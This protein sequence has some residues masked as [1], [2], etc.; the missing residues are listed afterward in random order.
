MQGK[1]KKWSYTHPKRSLNK[2]KILNLLKK[3]WTTGF[4][5]KEIIQRTALTK[6]TVISILEELLS[7]H[8]IFKLANLYFPEFDDDF[9]FGYFLSDYINFIPTNIIQKKQTTSDLTE[10][11]YNTKLILKDLLDNS[12]FAFSN[13]MGGLITY[14]LIESSCLYNYEREPAKIKELISNIFKGLNWESIFDQF[15]NLFRNDDMQTTLDKRGSDRLSESLKNV[16]PILYET[17]ETNKIEFF[18]EWIKKDPRDSTLYEKCDHEWKERY[19]FRCGKYK[20]CVHCHYHRL[21]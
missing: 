14:A 1:K 12:I 21:K 13:A 4:K 18:K 19:M 7:E 9:R 20:E 17:L 16:Y 11:S 5:Q 2:L 15:R 3:H 6:P 8:K 10:T